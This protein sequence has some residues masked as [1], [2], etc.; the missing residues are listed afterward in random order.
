MLSL[1][2]IFTLAVLF[3]ECIFFT[4][5]IF[6]WWSLVY[7]LKKDEIF[8]N[9]CDNNT[10]VDKNGTSTTEQDCSR[11]DSM[12]SLVYT[13]TS[14]IFGLLSFPQGWIFDKFGIRW[15]RIYARY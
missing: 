8:S 14:V 4:G 10:L 12:M 13:V 11:Q 3:F 15:S 1:K 7:V 2:I 5:T 9:L 6:G